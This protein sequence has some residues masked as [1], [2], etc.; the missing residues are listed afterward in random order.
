MTSVISK[1]DTGL[2]TLLLQGLSKPKFYGDL[3]YKFRKNVGTPKFSDQF[4]KIVISYVRNGYK[5]DVIKQS[6]CL[7]VDP[8]TG[9]FAYLLNW[10]PV[11]RG[12]DL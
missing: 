4:S 9:D 3:V 10:T 11:G 8:I 1:Y 2:K 6:A 7:A 12:S 5:I